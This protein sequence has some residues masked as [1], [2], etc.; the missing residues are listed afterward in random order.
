MSK[1]SSKTAAQ[2]MKEKRLNIRNEIWGEE[3]IENKKLW[4][5]L[6]H[7]GFTTVPRTMPYLMRIMDK[8]SGKG[9]PVSSTYFALWSNVFDEN[10][11]EIKEKRRYAFESGFSGERAVTTWTT[12]MRKLEKLGFIESKN[13]IEGEFSYV[14][15][16]NP[17][18]VV[19]SLYSG[20]P[21][22]EMYNALITRMSDV[23]SKF[24]KE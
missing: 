14:L 5:R 4:S 6:T 9:T 1:R 18:E 13:G 19:K 2:K 20:K 23:G 10:F 15:L 12:R 22:D 21:K 17:L 11:L 8:E 7:D 24:E 3:E 16:I